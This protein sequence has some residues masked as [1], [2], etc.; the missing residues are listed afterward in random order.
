M[1]MVV[2]AET[3]RG[4]GPR[5]APVN[6]V[7]AQTSPQHPLTAAVARTAGQLLGVARS[8]STIDALVVA[9]ALDCA[10]AMIWTSDPSDLRQLVGSHRGVTV[11]SI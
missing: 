8:S 5:D 3:V 1:P 9:E 7:L 6:L 4:N 2:V 11:E 10:P